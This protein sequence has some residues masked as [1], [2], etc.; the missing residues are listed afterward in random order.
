MLCMF[1]PTQDEFDVAC[2][3]TRNNKKMVE[4]NVVGSKI[5]TSA[6][7]SINSNARMKLISHVCFPGSH[8]FMV[9]A[10]AEA[11]R[12]QQATKNQAYLQTTMKVAKKRKELP[13]IIKSSPRAKKS[14][15]DEDTFDPFANIMSSCDS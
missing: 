3:Q 11:L 1:L 13:K 14:I 8:F 6:P 2:L 7:S 12:K 5:F 15:K 10:Y 4:L 9:K